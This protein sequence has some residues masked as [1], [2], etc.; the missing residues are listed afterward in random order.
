MKLNDLEIIHRGNREM[1]SNP[2]AIQSY[3]YA[4]EDPR[5]NKIFYIGKGVGN[6]VFE[7]AKDALKE[8]TNSTDKIQLIRDILQEDKKVNTYI[9]AHK[10]SERE[11]FL[12]E[13]SLIETLKTL[14][15]DLTNIVSG[16]HNEDM[17]LSTD[18]TERRYGFKKITELPKNSLV[19]NININYRKH[20]TPEQIYQAVKGTWVISKAYLDKWEY[21]FAEANNRVVGVYKNLEWY[22]DVQE[23]KTRYGFD[24]DIVDDSV[25]MNKILPLKKHGAANPIRLF[26]NGFNLDEESQ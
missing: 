18:E 10:L 7:H 2:D 16:H 13:S 22:P 24:G 12:I 15:S 4:L 3:V 5:D 14:G 19:I 9:I 25:Y 17:F 23:K 21:V 20:H 26:K 8:A 6:R 11:A 1:F